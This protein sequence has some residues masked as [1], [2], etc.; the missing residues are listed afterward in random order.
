MEYREFGQT[1][2]R[3]SCLGFGG[4]AISGEGGG[5]GFG[6]ISETDAIDLVKRAYDL[7]INLFD[8]APIYGFGE[9][10]RRMGKAL[11]SIR[12]KVWIVSKSGVSWHP[13]RRVN[14]SNDPKI[15]LN[16]LEQSLRDLNTDYIDLFM[17]HWPDQRVDIRRPM[18]VLAKAQHEKKIRFIGLSNT[19]PDDFLKASEIAKVEIL[20]AEYNAFTRYPEEELWPLL[21]SHH[22]GFMSWG[23]LD[24]GILTGRVSDEK[25]KFDSSDA[26]SHAPWWK[27]QDR[28]WKYQVVEKLKPVLDE[29]EV[30]PLQMCVGYV[31]SQPQVSTA[32]CGA[33]TVSQLEGLA[34]A[35]KKPLPA[36]LF[37]EIRILVD[38]YRPT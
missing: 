4:A 31:L 19:F 35:T 15:T 9:S 6:E 25:R 21:K 10:E 13:N 36:E 30:T 34:A 2:F 28:S 38:K 32:L 14:M 29:F 22:L 27:G 18:E 33:R 37:N 24:K 11:R 16:M 7:G 8:T 12:D 20:Q 5:Y 17:I 26:R 3:V 1:G 23:T